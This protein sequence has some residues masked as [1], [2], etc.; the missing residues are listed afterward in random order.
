MS[1]IKTRSGIYI[2]LLDP[3][4]KHIIIEDIAFALSNICRFTGHCNFYSVAEH[5]INVCNN[6]EEEYKFCGL[7]HDA[8]EAYLS[9]ISTPL[10]QLLPEYKRIELNMWKIIA[11][12]FELPFE[13][14]E[15]VHFVD[16]LMLNK[17][18]VFLSDGRYK[19]MKP[20]KSR[21]E[22]L[23]LYDSIRRTNYARAT[24]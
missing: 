22:F 21:K 15:E 17:E 11:G 16:K 24:T 9:D 12:K 20:E 10:K 14:P 5:S 6:L 1:K 13:M 18:I 7:M 2:D 8:T 4:P 19:P 3:D 23:K